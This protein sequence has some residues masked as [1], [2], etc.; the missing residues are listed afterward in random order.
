[1]IVSVVDLQYMFGISVFDSLASA[2]F[3]SLLGTTVVI[4]SIFGTQDGD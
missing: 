3:V 1:M 2:P 4:S